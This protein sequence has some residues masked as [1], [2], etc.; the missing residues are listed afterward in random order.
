MS[1]F[2]K[3]LAQA[4][5][6]LRPSRI[7]GGLGRVLSGWRGADIREKGLLLLVFSPMF[8]CLAGLLFGIASFVL[9]VLPALV[10]RILGWGLLTA[11]FGAGGVYCWERL[12]GRPL[13]GSFQASYDAT[14]T[15][16]GQ[17]TAQ[18]EERRRNEVRQRWFER[19]RKGR[20][21]E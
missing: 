18:D 17:E 5:Y 21:E 20:R 2:R 1:L 9:F 7:L 3:I 15:E 12:T 13:D 10:A 11:L 8:V 14:F 16:A 19:V 4:F 6:Y